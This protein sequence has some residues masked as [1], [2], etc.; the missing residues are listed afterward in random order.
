MIVK[1]LNLMY[2]SCAVG[3]V[4]KEIMIKN[5]KKQNLQLNLP[6]KAH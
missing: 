1:H 5:K 3:L 4:G 6:T 2:P